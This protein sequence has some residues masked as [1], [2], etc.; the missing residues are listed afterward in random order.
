MVRMI[1]G[2]LTVFKVVE[3]GS[4]KACSLSRVLG[5]SGVLEMPDSS[6]RD[7]GETVHLKVYLLQ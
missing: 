5:Y 6:A 1:A 2:C 3:T 7:L 4:D